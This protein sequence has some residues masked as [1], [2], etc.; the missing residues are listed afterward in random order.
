M[1]IAEVLTSY[2][3][4][5]DE[6]QITPCDE[7]AIMS[8]ETKALKGAAIFCLGTS[9]MQT[10]ILIREDRRDGCLDCL[11]G[12]PDYIEYYYPNSTRQE[13]TDDSAILLISLFYLLHDLSLAVTNAFGDQNWSCVAGAAS[14]AR[15]GVVRGS[16]TPPA[17][18]VAPMTLGSNAAA[19]PDTAGFRSVDADAFIK[20]NRWAI[21]FASALGNPV[22]VQDCH[23]VAI[24][25]APIRTASRASD[26]QIS[27]GKGLRIEQSLASCLGEGLE[28]YCPATVSRNDVCTGTELEMPAAV[29]AAAKFGLP[30][31]DSHPSLVAYHSELPVEWYPA[32]DLYTERDVLIPANFVFCPYTA[33]NGHTIS[34]SSTNG[35]AAGADRTDAR[36][37]ALREIIERDAFW[38]YARTGAPPLHID[39]EDLPADVRVRMA[40]FSGQ[41]TFSLLPNPFYAPVANVSFESDSGFH[42]KTARGSGHSETAQ[43]SLRRAFVECVQM[44]YSLDSGIEVEPTDTDMRSIWFTGESKHIFPNMFTVCGEPKTSLDRAGKFF[45]EHQTLEQLI[46]S[47]HLQDMSVFEMNVAEEG[48]FTVVKVLLSGASILDATY[49]TGCNRLAEFAE[50]LTHNEPQLSYTGSLF[51]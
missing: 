43:G 23:D 20:A 13:F 48:S 51:M 27:G 3:A 35:A 14:C 47:A 28:R 34:S 2:L 30:S 29:D 25:N 1:E 31:A 21:S 22:R 42:T 50:T 11:S 41:F 17:V 24:V 8:V 26:C 5:C 19:Q 4:I 16:I 40:Q 49:F 39:E 32:R 46:D 33:V 15:C 37:Q 38:Y 45:I 9:D 7:S 12:I 36:L 10:W 18:G 6:L 44:L